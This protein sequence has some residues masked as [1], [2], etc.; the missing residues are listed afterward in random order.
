M[1]SVRMPG[2]LELLLISWQTG[3]KPVLTYFPLDTS[4]NVIPGDTVT[5]WTLDSHGK[6]GGRRSGEMN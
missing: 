5:L 1:L 4:D 6:A 3:L 2:R